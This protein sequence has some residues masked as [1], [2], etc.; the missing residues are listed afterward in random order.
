VTPS[1]RTTYAYVLRRAREQRLLTLATTRAVAERRA[2]R[3]ETGGNLIS[4][5][6]GEIDALIIEQEEQTLVE[7]DSALRRLREAPDSYGICERCGQPIGADFL[8][9][10]PWITFCERH[11]DRSPALLLV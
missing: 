5:I 11:E 4:A 9:V 7:I 8:S 10:A 6:E 2:R 1:T 3:H